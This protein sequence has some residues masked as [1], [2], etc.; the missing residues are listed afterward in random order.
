MPWLR[1]FLIQQMIQIYKTSNNH[2]AEGTH[3]EPV[4]NNRLRNRFNNAH[5]DC[6]TFYR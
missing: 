3:Y 6:L 2:G 4:S 5:Y 1:I